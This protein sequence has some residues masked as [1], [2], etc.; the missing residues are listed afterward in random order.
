[1]E[2]ISEE[3]NEVINAMKSHVEEQLLNNIQVI[4]PKI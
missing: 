3:D 2:M 4:Y 1:M